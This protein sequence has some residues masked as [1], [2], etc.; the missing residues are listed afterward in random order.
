[1][2]FSGTPC[3]T[4]ALKT[5]LGEDFNEH[6]I[7]QT[8]L[9]HGVASPK[10][11]ER[12]LDDMEIKYRKKVKEIFFR[13][14]EH[15]W[16]KYGMKICF[17]DDEEYF[18]ESR[19]DTFHKAFGGNLALRNSCYDCKFKY[20]NYKADIVLGDFWN[21]E[22]ICPEIFNELGVS[23]IIVASSKGFDLFNAMKKNLTI[24]QITVSDIVKSQKGIIKS[25]PMNSKR[26]EFFENLDDENLDDLVK[27]LT[28]VPLIKK[29]RIGAGKIYRRSLSLILRRMI[30]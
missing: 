30:K 13:S 24:K 29:F 28:K 18:C 15:G 5:F 6:L 4:A 23:V 9:C 12:Y 14:K 1:M 16:E 17:E 25:T 3:Q 8:V 26:T 11:F 20:P 7:T 2:L 27:R 19:Q 21:V 10:V 22:S